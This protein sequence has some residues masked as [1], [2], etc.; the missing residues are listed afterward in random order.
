MKKAVFLF[1]LLFCLLLAL[2]TSACSHTHTLSEWRDTT[3]ATCTTDGVRERTCTTCEYKESETV[4]ALEHDLQSYA[5]QEPTCTAVGWNAYVACSRCDYTTYVEKPLYGHSFWNRVCTDCG[6]LETTPGL[7]YLSNGDGTCRVSFS[8]YLSDQVLVIPDASPDGDRVVS[9]DARAFVQSDFE[10]VYL[11][12]SIVEIQ[13]S[14]FS[15][16]DELKTLVLPEGSQLTTIGENAF[17]GCIALEGF[18]LPASV[19]VIGK[20]AFFGCRAITE[21][22][23]PAGLLTLEESVFEA[24]AS[25]VSVR[26]DATSKLTK[27]GENAFKNCSALSEIFIPAGVI[28]IDRSAF[29]N[30]T[31]LK[32]VIFDDANRLEIIRKNTFKNCTELAN[33]NLPDTLMNIEEDAF[34]NCTSAHRIENGVF[35]IDNYAVGCDPSLSSI[36]VREGTRGVAPSAFSECEN[37]T[38]IS[39]PEGLVFLGKSAVGSCT[40][41]TSVSLPSTL[42]HMDEFVFAGCSQLESIT[43]PA[44]VKTIGR[45]SF[46]NAGL[47]HIYF[48]ETSGWRSGAL[49]NIDVASA[50]DNAASFINSWGLSKLTRD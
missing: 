9:I 32:D 10:T 21:I 14:A 2:S 13:N 46:Y 38:D 7:S 8:G 39:F 11:P 33:I 36:T 30:C 34:L 3:P 1:T 40:K 25:L 44:A 29:E 27:I 12:T 41:L 15:G 47:K 18:S 19:T 28:T 35:Y 17:S 31:A 45:L 23:L 6:A 48:E 49:K 22:D 20:N 4:K 24:C 43:I 5:A 26:I 50:A 37:L 16:C 42:V